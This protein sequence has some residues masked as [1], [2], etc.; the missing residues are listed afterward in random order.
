[1]GAIIRLGW[2][3]DV[4]VDEIMGKSLEGNWNFWTDFYVKQLHLFTLI[5]CWDGYYV[6]LVNTSPCSIIK[7]K[8]CKFAL[9]SVLMGHTKW[10]YRDLP[11]STE[12][13]TLKQYQIPGGQKVI[14]TLIKAM[15]EVRVLVPTKLSYNSPV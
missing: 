4:M 5:Y 12:V 14:A 9:Q 13:V 11:E 7:L 3:G 10:Q 2:L 8:S 6:W 1:M 15:L